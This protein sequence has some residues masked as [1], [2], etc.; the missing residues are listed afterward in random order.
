[1]WCQRR[2]SASCARRGIATLL[3]VLVLVLVVLLEVVLL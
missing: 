2:R 1:M 3:L